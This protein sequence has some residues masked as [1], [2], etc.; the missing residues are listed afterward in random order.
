MATHRGRCWR[1]DPAISRG[2][3]S[4]QARRLDRPVSSSVRA[5][6]SRRPSRSARSIATDASAASR[7]STVVMRTDTLSS[8]SVQARASTP[9]GTPLLTIGCH[10]ADR[11]STPSTLL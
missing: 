6:D 10:R 5:T 11:R 8:R 7:S 2:S 4:S 9:I 1:A 3:C